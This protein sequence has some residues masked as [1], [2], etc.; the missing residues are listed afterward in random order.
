MFVEFQELCRKRHSIRKFTDDPVGDAQL[1]RLLNIVQL[2]PSAGNLQAYEIIVVKD[3][4]TKI[5]LAE[6]CGGQ[7]FIAHVP[8]VL[9]FNALPTV[10]SIR[11]KERGER[12]Y[13]IQDAS[14]ACT[15]AM[16]A[17]T[18]LGLSSVWVGAYDD[19]KVKEIIQSKADCIPVA[20]LPIGY[21][22]ETGL[23]KPRRS[24]EN[25]VRE[26]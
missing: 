6:A 1:E 5:K 19:D 23:P 15:Y 2:A 12:L 16:L 17:A 7:N 26:L 25:L 21:Q 22:A 4:M 13:C 11:Y 8:V 20:I 14:I 9:V 3:A 18:A 24:I 10:S